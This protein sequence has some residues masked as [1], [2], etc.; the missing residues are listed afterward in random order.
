M[1]ARKEEDTTMSL[2]G[3]RVGTLGMIAVMSLLSPGVFAATTGSVTLSGTVAASTAI[4]VT[5]QNNFNN[6]DLSTSTTDL[7]VATVREINNTSNGYTVTMTSQN[8]G[9]LKNGAV[10]QVAYTAKYNGTA[11]TLSAIPQTVTTAGPSGTV[12]N[13]LKNFQITYTGQPAGS[14]MQ[15]TYSD[16]LTFTITAL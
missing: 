3:K 2:L 15:G 12:V 14:L 9:Q 1:A 7:T 5:G 13:V 10:G 16:T 8:A 6:L 11:A 4:V